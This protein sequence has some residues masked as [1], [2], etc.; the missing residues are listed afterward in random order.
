[1]TTITRKPT[2]TETAQKIIETADRLGYSIQV[3]G[4]VMSISKTFA[5][6]DREAFVE[7]DGTYYDV[8]S[9]LP[10]TEAGSDWGTDGSG[11]GGAV[12]MREGFFKMNR[13]GGSKRVLA[14]LAKAIA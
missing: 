5:P 7:C 1:M 11:I 2:P 12:A 3:S 6:N 8:L 13:S 4:R 14:A 10:R 9:L